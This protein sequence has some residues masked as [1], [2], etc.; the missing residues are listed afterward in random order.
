MFAASLALPT[1]VQAGDAATD[2]NSSMGF[3]TS[4]D[5]AVRFNAAQALNQLQKGGSGGQGGGTVYCQVLGACPTG[6]TVTQWNGVTVNSV[7][8]SSGI[9]ID[10]TINADAVQ[11]AGI[12]SC[13]DVKDCKSNF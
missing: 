1:G 12:A 4:S 6:G 5:F 7:S 3:M 11:N 8:N 9:T 10:N 13:T 2:W